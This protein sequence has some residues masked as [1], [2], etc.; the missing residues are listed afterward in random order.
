MELWLNHSNPLTSTFDP[1]WSC[2]RC[3][4]TKGVSS[5][6]GHLCCLWLNRAYPRNAKDHV[7]LCLQMTLTA[8]CIVKRHAFLS[9]VILSSVCMLL[10]PTG[11]D[12]MHVKKNR[13]KPDAAQF[14]LRPPSPLPCSRQ[15]SSAFRLLETYRMV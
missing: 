7:P 3:G 9:C 5:C 6:L 14:D 8:H 2:D 15:T 4:V 13:I 11:G 1:R 10:C 12:P